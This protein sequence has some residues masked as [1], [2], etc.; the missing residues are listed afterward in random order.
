MTSPAFPTAPRFGLLKPSASAIATFRQLNTTAPF[1]YTSI[2]A[3]ATGR[4]PG[5]RVDHNRIHLGFGEDVWR[6]ARIAL[7]RWE[8]FPAPWAA[9]R[10]DDE[11]IQPG[12]TLTMLAH[13]CGLWWMSGCRI[14][15]VIEES[16]PV[17]R[18]GFA[19]GTLTSHVEQGEEC[20]MIEMLE[21]GSVWYDLRAFSR[22]R[23]WPV[24]LTWPL[25]R[26]LQKRF[27]RESLATL[28]RIA[29]AETPVPRTS[30]PSPAH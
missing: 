18:S 21:D 4:P 10:P 22:P 8:M 15:Y 2:G 14:A 7:H 12:L 23:F 30:S 19:Y 13:A 28:R 5:Y 1:S 27:V 3:S 9:I 17:R 24:R 26:R 16:A 20:F 6:R 11:P 29:S 25:A